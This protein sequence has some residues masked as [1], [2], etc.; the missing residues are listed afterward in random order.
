MLNMRS[1]DDRTTIARIRDAAIEQFGQHGFNV[2]LRAIARP[3]GS[4][5]RW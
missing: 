4:A 3:R 5:P 2:G 1:V